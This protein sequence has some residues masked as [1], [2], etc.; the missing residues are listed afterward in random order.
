MANSVKILV[1]YHKPSPLLPSETFVAINGGR[2]LLSGNGKDVEW[3]KENTIGDDTGDNISK[4]NR[5][6]NEMTVLYWAWKNYE[7]L[8]NP[9]YI[10]F[11]HYR[12]HFIFKEWTKPDGG[13]WEF[14]PEYNAEKYTD[15]LA[16]SQENI[17]RNLEGNDCIYALAETEVT[18]YEQYRNGPMHLIEDLDL[19]LDI[20]RRSDNQMIKIAAEKYIHGK[21]NY[22][23]NMFIMRKKLFHEYCQWIFPILEEFDKQRNYENLSYEEIRFFVSERLTGIFIQYLMDKGAKCKPLPI[24]LIDFPDN[25]EKLEPAFAENNIPVVFSVDDTY[26]PMLSVTLQSLIEHSSAQK[27]YDLFVLTENLN[28]FNKNMLQKQVAGRK[29][30]SLRFFSVKHL[31]TD[32]IRK[33]L[34]IEIHVSLATYFRFFIPRIFNQFKKIIYLDADLLICNDIAKLF[35]ITLHDNWLAAVLDIRESIPVK[36]KMKVSGQ[37]W[38]EYVTKVLKLKDPYKYFQAGVLIYDIQKFIENNLELRLFKALDIIKVPILS[39]Q[40]IMNAVFYG[41]VEFIPTNWNLEWQIPLEFNDYRKLLPIKY[42]EAYQTA[43]ENPYIIHYASSRKPWNEPN[44]GLADKWW[45]VAKKTIYYNYFLKRDFSKEYSLNKE[46]LKIINSLLNKKALF[47]KISYKLS[48][49]K[50]KKRLKEKYNNIKNMT[51]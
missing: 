31:I 5:R 24:T 4:E 49:G 2:A 6:Y 34:Y 9:E 20:I 18:V 47:Y 27:N 15:Y 37:N 29:N 3:L 12:R 38:H 16:C 46:Q 19:I 11:M 45:E 22:F 48:I 39:D 36:L 14:R 50:F 13:Q 23:A 43:L 35:E 7:K 44:I 32:E 21:R 17:R 8:E 1:A 25:P 30:F 41:H 40:D 42:F 51:K 28:A 10:G 33:K 26:A